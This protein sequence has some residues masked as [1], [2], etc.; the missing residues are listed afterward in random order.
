MRIIFSRKGFDAK[1]GGY[2]SPIIN[3]KPCSLPIPKG[4]SNISYSDI[5]SAQ[6]KLVSEITRKKLTL[7]VPAT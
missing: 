3:G 6:C 7:T 4:P 5:N 2:P 1:N